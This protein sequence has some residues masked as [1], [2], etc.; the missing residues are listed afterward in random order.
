MGSGEEVAVITEQLVL[1]YTIFALVGIPL[2]LILGFILSR[3]VR[4]R[5]VIAV[6]AC[7]EWALRARNSPAFKAFAVRVQ[8]RFLAKNGIATTPLT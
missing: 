1:A 8:R 5:S 4:Y 6:V 3:S 2:A 7:Y